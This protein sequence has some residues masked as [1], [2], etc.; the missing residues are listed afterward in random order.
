M[1]HTHTILRDPFAVAAFF[2]TCLLIGT[3]QD[4]VN[5]TLSPTTRTVVQRWSSQP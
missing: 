4:I 3:A 5:G 1:N 2:A